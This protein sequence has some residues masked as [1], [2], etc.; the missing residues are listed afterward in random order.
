MSGIDELG[1]PGQYHLRKR[2]IFPRFASLHE[3][4]S[5][6]HPLTRVKLLLFNS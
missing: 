1:R 5:V 2:W 4:N 3:V 6:S